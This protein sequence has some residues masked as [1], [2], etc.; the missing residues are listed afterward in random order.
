MGVH[1]IAITHHAPQPRQILKIFQPLD[2]A[3][4][5]NADVQTE[6][7]KRIDLPRQRSEGVGP[8]WP[9]QL[10]TYHENFHG[11]SSRTAERQDLPTLPD[12]LISNDVKD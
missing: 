1:D 10:R 7:A 5:E 9:R 3:H 6:V 12:D 2:P 11:V 8:T 4:L